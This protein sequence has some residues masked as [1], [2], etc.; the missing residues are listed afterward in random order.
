MARVECGPDGR[1]VRLFGIA[2][3]ITERR[4]SEEEL[5]LKNSAIESSISG[6]GITDLEGRMVYVNDSLVRM[7]G[8]SNR[9][10]I[11]GR[12]LPDFWEGE[13]IARTVEDLRT[14]GVS[15]GEDIG[16]KKDGSLFPVEYSAS[17]LKDGQGNPVN[18]YGSFVDAPE[19][20]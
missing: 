3:D 8:Y 16:R 20:L 14:K 12:P 11:L 5:K 15:T 1:P 4:L 10:E 19:P 7:W 2:Q 17:M 6:V 18:M 13:G 9:D